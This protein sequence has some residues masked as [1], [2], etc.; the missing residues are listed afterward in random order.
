[1]ATWRGPSAGGSGGGRGGGGNRGGGGRYQGGGGGGGGGPQ[2]YLPPAGAPAPDAKVTEIENSLISGTMTS[3]AGMSLNQA[4]PT[5][6]SYGTNGAK[7]VLWANYFTLKSSEDLVLYQYEIKVSPTATGRKLGHVVQLFLESPDLH[8]LQQ[9]IVTDFRAILIARLKVLVPAVTFRYRAEG[10]DEARENAREYTVTLHLKHTFPIADLMSYLTS[11]DASR[12]REE[13]SPIQALNILFNH[14]AK[15]SDQIVTRG[16]SKSYSLVDADTRDLEAGLKAIRGFFT[17]VRAA[18][19]R[20]LLNI[21]VSHAAFY[22]PVRLDQLIMSFLQKNNAAKLN[23]FLKKLRVRTTHLKERK[24]KRGEIVIRAKTISGLATSKDGENL[25]HP[26]R[27][28]GHGAGPKDVEFWLEDRSGDKASSAP[29]KKGK[30]PVSAGG[31]YTSVYD[32]FRSTYNTQMNMKLPVVNVGT[33]QDPSYLPSEVCA[34]LPGQPASNALSLAQRQAMIQ[35]A[36]RGPAA[37]AQSIVS[38]GHHIAGIS[39]DTSTQINKFGVTMS[40]NLITVQGRLLAEPKVA[41][42]RNQQA[43]VM[44]G[45]WNMVPRGSAPLKFASSNV[46]QAW[47]CLYVDMPSLYPDAWQCSKEEFE[48]LMKT[49][50]GVLQSTGIQANKPV[51]FGRVV[52]QE[53]DYTALENFM[54]AAAANVQ[55][56]FVILPHSPIP[57]YN[58]IKQ[59]GDV[60]YGVHTICSVGSKIAKGGDQYLRNEALKVN[61]KLG[62][63]NHLVQSERLGLIAQNKTMVVGIDVT[64][65]DAGSS[66]SAPSI[67]AM[68]ASVDTKLSQWPGVL[69]YQEKSRQEMV[70]HLTVMLKSRLS[71]WRGKGKHATYPENIVVYRDG[72]SEGQYDTVLNKELPQLRAACEELYPATDQAKGLPRMSIIIVGKRHHT[73]FYVTKPSDADR[74]GNSKAGT[75]VDRGV[76]EARHWDFF[77][78]SHAAIKGT[79]RPAHYVVLLD[80]IFRSA[81]GKNVADELQMVTQSLCYPFGR[82]TKAVSYCVPA[83]L[84]DVL[85]ERGRRYAARHYDSPS[86]S[87]APSV[88]GDDAPAATLNQDELKI[89]DRLKDS[90]FYI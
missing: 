54:S 34:V 79:A 5:R 45:S 71:L 24:N 10:E 64:H 26:P 67:A 35:F 55:L 40:P 11:T 46:L 37:N 69:S 27:V 81:K 80:E 7:L 60:K 18:T 31:R 56:V 20:M 32:Y 59:L 51:R 88:A 72:V 16:T 9:D 63:D 68:V 6:P 33:K 2:I 52:L 85:C 73:R 39:T 84:A 1:M 77:L 21:N 42:G 76:T 47:A 4:R 66:D 87:T 41:Y 82:A 12:W 50:H 70:S 30:K 3:L 83:Y 25:D 19:G 53:N 22:Q 44:N 57:V 23:S 49:F 75:V 17:S 14:H 15:S 8:P 36:V 48:D 74:S 86:G 62:G 78:Q 89:H 29:K 13:E 90:M 28:R 43:S 65:P 38:E 58:N 61:L